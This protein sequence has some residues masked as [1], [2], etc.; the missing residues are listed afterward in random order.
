MKE[1]GRLEER[2]GRKEKGSKGG[3]EGNFPVIE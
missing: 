1:G 2:E 3:M